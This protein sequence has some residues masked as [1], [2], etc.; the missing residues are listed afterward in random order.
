MGAGFVASAIAGGEKLAE[1][2]IPIYNY[3][4]DNLIIGWYKSN[5]GIKRKM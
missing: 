3:F 2:R 4:V 5:P 1:E